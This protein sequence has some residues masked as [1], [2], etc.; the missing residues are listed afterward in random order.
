MGASALQRAT[1]AILA[2]AS[3]VAALGI[4]L[5][6]HHDL[7]SG[8]SHRVHEANRHIVDA[9][10]A[11]TYY[12][13]DVADMV[14]V[15]DDADATEFSRYAHVRGRN[16]GAIVGVQWLRRSPSGRL[17]P[18]KETGP[19]PILV[20][21][22]GSDA[23]LVDAAGARAAEAAVRTASLRKRVAV[24]APVALASGHAGFYLAVPVE[25]HHFS[26]EVSKME[27]R[28]AIV[29]LIDAQE[30]VAQADTGRTLAALRLSDG[31][32]SLATIGSPHQ[33]IVRTSLDAGGR[34]WTLSIDGG[35]LST[36]EQALPWLVLVFGLGLT[37][38]VGLSLRNSRQ[39]R[40][41]ALRL[42]HDRSE[43]LSVTLKR[44][45]RT[46]LDLEQAHAEADRL[47]RVDPLTDIFNRRHLGEVLSAELARPGGGSAAVLL[48]DLDHFK[49]VNDRYG[50]RTGDAVLQ[51][52]AA[53]IASITRTA[54][55]LARW[56]GE[57]FAILAPG[58]GRDGAIRLAERARA[59]LADQPVQVDDAS[60]ELTLS[61]GVAVAGSEAQTPDQLV[62]AADE[63]LYEA[64]RAGRNCI[65]VFQRKGA[66]DVPSPAV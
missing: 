27:S 49:S 19:D 32:T 50:H 29:G 55:C 20:P 34:P 2:A 47:S 35:A 46:N 61:V 52:A 1:V 64:K 39:R 13:Q 16:E 58:I 51:A 24:S 23:E 3:A 44:V 37:L 43:E 22:S 59:A 66:V 10:R 38:A 21:G 42:A 60:I 14:G 53:R 41:A 40:D 33:H 31:P 62:D 18:P 65:R 4:G 5:A 30:L 63:A 26:G 45:E 7:D 15:H 8:R 57:E 28:S 56:G 25:A 9:L 6:L 11:R 12:L 48:L 36:F 17:Q 54:D